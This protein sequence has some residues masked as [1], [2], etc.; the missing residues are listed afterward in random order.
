MDNLIEYYFTTN[1]SPI[2]SQQNNFFIF[3]FNKKEIILQEHFNQRCTLF[4]VNLD[5]L[6]L[7]I[8]GQNMR[9]EF[10]QAFLVKYKKVLTYIH[11]HQLKIYSKQKDII[12]PVN[13]RVKNNLASIDTNKNDQTLHLLESK[14]F[15]SESDLI[16]R[17]SPVKDM[18]LYASLL[19]DLSAV[20]QKLKESSMTFTEVA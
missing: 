2:R 6:T 9:Q 5:R 16:N 15:I 12:P 14:K 7:D 11:Q 20:A 10:N 8:D 19:T 13:I 3:T 4:T 18:D 17:V 1:I